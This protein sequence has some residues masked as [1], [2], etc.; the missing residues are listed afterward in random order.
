MKKLGFL[1]LFLVLCFINTEAQTFSTYKGTIEAG[2]NKS[3]TGWE[4]SEKPLNDKPPKIYWSSAE[5]S[6]QIAN[7]CFYV[8]FGL[9]ED[10]IMVWRTFDQNGR[11]IVDPTDD[12]KKELIKKNPYNKKEKPMK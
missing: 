9:R 12:F 4:L 8:S 1:L 6:I 2:N 3:I 7:K 5:K 10:G 11:N